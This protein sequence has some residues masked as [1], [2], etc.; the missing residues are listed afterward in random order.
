MFTVLIISETELD[1]VERAVLSAW[2]KDWGL[3]KDYVKFQTA[4]LDRAGKDWKRWNFHFNFFVVVGADCALA[5]KEAG[6]L[7]YATFSTVVPSPRAYLKGTYPAPD[8]DT[9]SD[10]VGMLLR[11]YEKAMEAMPAPESN[12]V[13]SLFRSELTPS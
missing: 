6:G 3:V 9:F 11:A 2:F 12:T 13:V 8:R 1:Y 4:P 10:Y 5:L 7:P